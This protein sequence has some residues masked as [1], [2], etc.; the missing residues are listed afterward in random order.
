MTSIESAL[1]LA[2][3]SIRAKRDLSQEELADAA[4][5]HRTT[6]SLV[7]RGRISITVGTLEALAHALG[8]KPSELI[9][10]AE[11]QR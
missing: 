6:M 5:L 3:R 7:E 10:D 9:R 1:G 11:K 2:I 4:G 8:T